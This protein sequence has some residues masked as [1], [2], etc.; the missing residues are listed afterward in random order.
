M[1]FPGSGPQPRS[2]L[3]VVDM[4]FRA[5][6]SQSL[7]GLFSLLR[8]RRTRGWNQ[9]NLAASLHAAYYSRWIEQSEPWVKA[10][11]CRSRPAD[12]ALPRLACLVL[13]DDPSDRQ[14]CIEALTAS[15]PNA[16]V[17]P[18]CLKL[19]Q[20]LD[21]AEHEHC[22]WLLP[23]RASDRL[24][25]DIEEVLRVALVNDPPSIIFWDCDQIVDGERCNPFIKPDWDD[26]LLRDYDLLSGAALIALPEARAALQ[27][28]PKAPA[29]EQRI[30]QWLEAMLSDSS[31]RPPRHI[32]LILSHHNVSILGRNASAAPL[33]LRTEE[34][35][36][37]VSIII[38]TRDQT[39]LLES[40]LKSIGRRDYPGDVELIIVDNDSA[41]LETKMLFDRLKRDGEAEI[42]SFPGEFNF[43]AMMNDAA[44]RATGE[45][46]CFLNNDIEALDGDW[47]RHLVREAIAPKV[48]AVGARLLYP[49]GTIQHVGVAIGIGGGAGHVEKGASPD[50]LWLA[51]WHNATRR[52]SALTAACMVVN[53]CKFRTVG[54]MDEQNFAVDFNDVDLCLK[55]E[56][57]GL[58]NII[59]PKATL[60]HHESKSRGTVRTPAQQRRFER[61]LAALR[62]RWNT[63]DYRDPW[64]SP[65]FRPE[66]ERCLLR[67]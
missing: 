7:K 66:S 43:A 1:S 23:I 51:N 17:L 48:G 33:S 63:M 53:R 30:T 54:G 9:L 3:T 24:A 42:V 21:I 64:H 37:S 67:F 22:D 46:L 38:P 29:D 34:A 4:A 49:D 58:I 57:H 45:Y 5:S 12:L 13:G 20:S 60:M 35:W 62:G 15:L 40:C 65:L 27:V 44:R 26:F 8:R 55:L 10:A 31:D 39:Q 32:P 52:V 47:L 18:N 56:S 11:W 19:E 36:P 14:A 2:W 59:V 28:Y 50:D 25:P 16:T 61:E 41:E 6:I